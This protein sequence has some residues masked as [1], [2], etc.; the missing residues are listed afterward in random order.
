VPTSK[1]PQIDDIQYAR[2]LSKILKGASNEEIADEV[3]AYGV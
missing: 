3:V 1:R 2:I